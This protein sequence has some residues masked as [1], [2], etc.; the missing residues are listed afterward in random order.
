MVAGYIIFASILY[1]HHI[2]QRLRGII[3]P[4][5]MV[6]ATTAD[7]DRAPDSLNMQ[8]DRR[9]AQPPPHERQQAIYMPTLLHIS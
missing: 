2:V 1:S 8:N 3:A 7:E 6:I 4:K 9:K 5:A